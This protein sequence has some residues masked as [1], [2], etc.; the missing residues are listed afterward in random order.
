MVGE[1][2]TGWSFSV[3]EGGLQFN[4]MAILRRNLLPPKQYARYLAGDHWTEWNWTEIL[5]KLDTQGPCT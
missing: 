5:K 1:Q 4:A 3:K 2:G